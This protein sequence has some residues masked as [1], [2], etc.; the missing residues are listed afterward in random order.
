MTP[1]ETCDDGN[2][3]SG[4]G[5]DASCQPELGWSCVETTCISICGDNLVK[6]NEECDNL[7]SSGC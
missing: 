4:D 5:C 2:L 1:P 7:T 3:N 6:G